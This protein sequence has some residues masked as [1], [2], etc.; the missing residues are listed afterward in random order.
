MEILLIGILVVGGIVARAI[1]RRAARRSGGEII[2]A[3]LAKWAGPG[4]W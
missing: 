4:R 3:R 1:F 2:E